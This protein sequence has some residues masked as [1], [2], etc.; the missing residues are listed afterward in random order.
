MPLTG[1]NHHLHWLSSQTQP[2]QGQGQRHPGPTSDKG[3]Q[4]ELNSVKLHDLEK[5]PAGDM[6]LPQAVVS[7]PWKVTHCQETER[8]VYAEKWQIS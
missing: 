8:K 1:L 7:L 4:G 6:G 3:K 5:P 2:E